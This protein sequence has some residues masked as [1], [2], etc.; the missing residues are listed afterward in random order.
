MRIFSQ[1]RKDKPE[2]DQKNIRPILHQLGS[3]PRRFWDRLNSPFGLNIFETSV[4]VK[5][6]YGRFDSSQFR[7]CVIRTTRFLSLNIT[8]DDL[9]MPPD[10]L[11]NRYTLCGA[12][13]LHSPHYKL[14][15]DIS[16]GVLTR[17]SEYLFRCRSG[18]LDARLPTNPEPGVL[19]QECQLRRQDLLERQVMKVYVLEVPLGG[20]PKYMIVDGK[21]SAALIAYDNRP[22][23]LQLEF[24]S[25]EFVQE[26]FFLQV[27]SY[28]L[29]LDSREYSINQEMIKSIQ[30]ES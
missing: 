18:T 12:S 30:N 25:N 4:G 6:K 7:N 20:K 27:Y 5:Y 8:F 17:D 11:R 14:I 1:A 15:K 24:V 3:A 23:C 9:I 26:P 2:T 10:L 29:G 28:T 16:V 19:M 13:I 22:E 21:H